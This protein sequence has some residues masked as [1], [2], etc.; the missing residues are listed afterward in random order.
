MFYKMELGF[1][2]NYLS[3]WFLFFVSLCPIVF[4]LIG[5]FFLNGAILPMNASLLSCFDKYFVIKLRLLV[6]LLLS[7]ISL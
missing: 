3:Y 6:V 1:L 4:F 2:N 7:V 5:F